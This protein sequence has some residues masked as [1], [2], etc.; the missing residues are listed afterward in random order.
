MREWLAAHRSYR[1]RLCFSATFDRYGRRRVENRRGGYDHITVLLVDIRDEE[2]VVVA[3]HLWISESLPFIQEGI[4]K[5]E[6]VEFGAKIKTYLRGYFGRQS[7]RQQRHRK[8]T[9]GTRDYTL[10]Q[11]TRIHRVEKV[12]H[13]A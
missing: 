1:G 2:G 12:E 4:R 6:I 8:V 7:H 3:A 9:F 5:G 11:L 13:L 10:H